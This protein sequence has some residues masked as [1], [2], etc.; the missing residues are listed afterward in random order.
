MMKRNKI[1]MIAT[2]VI[3]MAVCGFVGWLLISASIARKIANDKR[4]ASFSSLTSIYK[5]KVFPSD[6]NIERTKANQKELE[7]WLLNVSNI[8]HKG[9]LALEQLTPT[10]FKQS[11]QATVRK[12]SRQPGSKN[13][14]VV[15]PKFHFGF[16]QYL[17]ESDSLPQAVHV[18]RLT[19][20]LRIIEKVCNELYEANVLSLESIER[21]HFESSEK[22]E[23]VKKSG[24]RRS[25]RSRSNRDQSKSGKSEVTDSTGDYFAKQRFTFEFIASPTAFVEALNKLASMDLFVVVAEAS[26]VKTGDQL[27][28]LQAGVKKNTEEGAEKKDPATMSHVQR[29]VTNP[30]IDPP[31]RVTLAID[32]YSF[33]G[34]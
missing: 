17:G 2:S 10:A 3:I 30:D 32:V 20:Q 14:K 27:A 7:G 11:L 31:V 13:G 22:K 16:D 24:N 9:D 12:L 5:A 1:I 34:V 18:S 19:T 26:F 21:E 15:L 23:V 28:A 29:M 4:N 6:E 25:R 8:L 33:K